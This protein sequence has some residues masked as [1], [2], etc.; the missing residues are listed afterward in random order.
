MKGSVDM[1][2]PIVMANIFGGW[3]FVEFAFLAII[4]VL[5]FGKRLPEVGKNL[6]KSIVEFK[7]GL[8]S[9]GEPISVDSPGHSVVSTPVQPAAL[10][11][12]QADEQNRQQL[13]EIKRL[14]DEVRQLKEQMAQKP[15][16]D[17]PTHSV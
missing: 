6:G 15:S 9:A 17:S 12:G 4:G 2:M 3:G 5:I 11:P 7:K 10:P 8:A 14:S 16:A 13:D 1:H